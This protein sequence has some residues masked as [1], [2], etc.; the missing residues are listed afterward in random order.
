MPLPASGDGHPSAEVCA[1]HPEELD[2]TI[3]ELL[4]RDAPLMS[5]RRVATCPVTLGDRRIEAGERLTI[6]WAS[7][8]RDEAVF[9]DPDAI[10]A[11][12]CLRAYPSQMYIHSNAFNGLLMGSPCV[13][14]PL[15]LLRSFCLPHR[16]RARKTVMWSLW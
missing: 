2:G 4:R 16:P 5:N 11:A 10:A 15:L 9:G 8:N 7:A 3:D 6:L 12:F 1:A 13:R 14:S